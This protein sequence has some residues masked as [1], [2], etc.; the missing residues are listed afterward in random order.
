MLDFDKI[1]KMDVLEG[2]KLIPDNS[3]DSGIS[4]PPYNKLGLL[5]GKKQKGGDWNGYIEY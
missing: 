4:S 2:L 1:Y 5:K 3:I